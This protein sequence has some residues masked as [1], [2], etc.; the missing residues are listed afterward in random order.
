MLHGL[1][2]HPSERAL[3]VRGV[4]VTHP[5]LS[6]CRGQSLSYV[7]L[8]PRMS[9]GAAGGA[10]GAGRGGKALSQGTDFVAVTAARL[11]V[12]ALLPFPAGDAWHALRTLRFDALLPGSVEASELLDRSD[13]A[14]GGRR[15][16]T[17]RD[18]AAWT[19]AVTALSDDARTVAWSVTSAEPALGYS[20][21]RDEV[22]IRDVSVADHV[23]DVHSP[24][25]YCSLHPVHCC[26][27][28]ASAA[29]V[30]HR[31]DCRLQCRCVRFSC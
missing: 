18:G 14:V 3:D 15:L 9:S 23:R 30:F 12:S 28:C 1:A 21:R 16:I 2:A 17:W 5:R 22:Q 6:K 26:H 4:R 29:D 31:V 13:T 7:V 25:S 8:S 24:T 27:L 11:H 10:G 19:V 20:S